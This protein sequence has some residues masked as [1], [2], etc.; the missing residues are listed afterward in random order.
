MK[1]VYQTILFQLFQKLFLIQET[2]LLIV[3]YFEKWGITLCVIQKAL[4]TVY[5]PKE[6]N[7]IYRYLDSQLINK[8]NKSTRI[9][10]RQFQTCAGFQMSG[11]T[12]DFAQKIMVS[13]SVYHI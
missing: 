5:M 7:T 6:Q 11:A 1:I 3:Q 4:L 12:K 2:Q 8:S 10:F 9:V 13:S